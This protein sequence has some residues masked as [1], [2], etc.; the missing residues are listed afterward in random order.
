MRI[1]RNR[2]TERERIESRNTRGEK[3][4]EKGGRALYCACVVHIAVLLCNQTIRG[5]E[6]RKEKFGEPYVHDS[7]HLC[8]CVCSRIQ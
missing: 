2:E 3:G 7:V 4:E 8:C 5:S 6:Y 1:R